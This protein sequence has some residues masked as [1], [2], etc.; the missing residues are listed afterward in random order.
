MARKRPDREV[1]YSKKF[2]AWVAGLNIFDWLSIS[3]FTCTFRSQNLLI[4]SC[5]TGIVVCEHNI[6]T[7]TFILGAPH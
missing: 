1:D 5:T 3:G 4:L 2:G 6:Q 7:Q